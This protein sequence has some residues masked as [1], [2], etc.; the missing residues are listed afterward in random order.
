MSRRSSPAGSDPKLRARIADRRPTSA[1]PA[2]A[3]PCGGC[4][5]SANSTP[6]R[7]ATRNTAATVG[8]TNASTLR[9]SAARAG[10]RIQVLARETVFSIAPGAHGWVRVVLKPPIVVSHRDAVIGICDRLFRSG[11]ELRPDTGA[12]EQRKR[13]S[14]R[15]ASKAKTRGFHVVILAEQRGPIGA[16]PALRLATL[17]PPR[18]HG[19]HRRIREGSSPR[20]CDS[21]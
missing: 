18:R 12:R 8:N 17:V 9:S 14:K 11:R 6:P 10:K 20:R 19:C 3:V 1:R 16:F 13:S 5:F 7:A 15:Q 21:G 4:L 2:A